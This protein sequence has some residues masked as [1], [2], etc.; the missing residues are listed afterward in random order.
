MKRSGLSQG[1]KPL[2]RKTPLAQREPLKRAREPLKRSEQLERNSGLKPRSDKMAK[3]YREERVPLVARL[4]EERPY[5]EAKIRDVC[6]RYSQ[7]IHEVVSRARGGSITDEANCRA[8]C[9]PC[10]TFITDH[11]AIA[12]AMELSKWSWER[13]KPE[14]EAS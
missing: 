12:A 14:Q 11:P 5:C 13:D 8:V 7:D 1:D 6:T 9:R 3:I 10:H 4:L 2:R